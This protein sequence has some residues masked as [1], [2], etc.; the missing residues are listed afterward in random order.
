MGRQ[1]NLNTVNLEITPTARKMLNKSQ[2][3][4]RKQTTGLKGNSHWR[5]KD[6]VSH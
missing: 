5:L 3:L 4:F 6:K 2:Y 1:I